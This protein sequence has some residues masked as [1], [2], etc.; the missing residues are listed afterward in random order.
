MAARGPLVVSVVVA[1]SFFVGGCGEDDEQPSSPSPAS[2][3]GSAEATA[4]IAR[5][6]EPVDIGGREL[7][8]ECWGEPVADEP[9]VLLISGSGP[10]TSYWETMASALAAEGHHLC[11]YDRAGVGGSDFAPELRRTTQDLVTDLVALLDVAELQEPVVVVAHSLGSLP[12][13]GLVDRVPERVAGVVLVDPVSP[14]IGA[15]QEAALPPRK[16]HESPDVTDERLF[17][18]DFRYDP[19]QNPEHLVVAASE[20][21]VARLLDEPGPVFGDLPVVVLQAP[22]PELLPGLPRSYVATAH[23]AIVDGNEELAAESTAGTVVRVEDTGHNIH[24]D[25]PGVVIDAIRD[26]MAG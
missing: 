25:Q 15:A 7:Y 9:T 26:V 4:E 13:V 6:A 23:T 8:L 11:G 20:E 21:E 18:T 10:T 19:S 24:E 2:A 16:P 1:M 14:R 5:S 3:S 17:L 22:L 12:A